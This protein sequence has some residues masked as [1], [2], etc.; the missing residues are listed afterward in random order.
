[1]AFVAG[2]IK[3]SFLRWDYTST[4]NNDRDLITILSFYFLLGSL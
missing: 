2:I 3:G 1:V 4:A